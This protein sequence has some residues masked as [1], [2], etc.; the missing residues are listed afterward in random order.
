M[1]KLEGFANLLQV[2]YYYQWFKAD[3]NYNEP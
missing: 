1:N 2:I 3:Q